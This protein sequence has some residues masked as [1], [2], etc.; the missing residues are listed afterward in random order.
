[1]PLPD[2]TREAAAAVTTGND[3]EPFARAVLRF[4]A[5]GF[6]GVYVH[7][8]GPDQPGFFRFWTREVAPFLTVSE[9]S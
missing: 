5:A 3:P 1:V 4:A 7:Q 6:S 8:V 2:L 9:A